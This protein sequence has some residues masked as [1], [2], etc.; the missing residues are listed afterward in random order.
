MSLKDVSWGPLLNPSLSL[1]ADEPSFLNVD[2]QNSAKQRLSQYEI[3]R[4]E[5]W[6]YTSLK[7]IAN[8]ELDTRSTSYESSWLMSLDE[9]PISF[10]SSTPKN[11]SDE[12][13]KLRI[14]KLSELATQSRDSL[15]ER[16]WTWL[17]AQMNQAETMHD[18]QS[19]HYRDG[20]VLIVEKDYVAGELSLTPEKIKHSF[21]TESNYL[22]LQSS[23]VWI[24]L[25]EG[26]CLSVIE[27]FESNKE[28]KQNHA[29][30]SLT[31][32][33]LS[34]R[35]KLDYIRS[36]EQNRGLETRDLHLGRINASVYAD[37]CLNL[38][39]L[40]LGADICRL[41]LDVNLEESRARAD[42]SGL[43]LGSAK[44]Q[45]DQHLT[46]RHKAASCRS[47]QCFKGALGAKSLGVFTGRV[48]V[49]EG[50][51][52]TVADQNNPNLL[53]SESAKAVTRPQLEIYNDD[54][55]CSHGATVGQLDEDALFYLKARGLDEA[56]ALRA[57]TSAF[58]GEIRET[59]P[60]PNLKQAID[61]SLK[62][63]LGIAF[64]DHE[65]EEWLD[66]EQILNELDVSEV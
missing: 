57:L 56:S 38:T 47:S 53:L 33:H 24:Y 16:A 66:W 61:Y 51:F 40:N 29:Q 58:V 6:R 34:A 17:K 23:N 32:M 30:L 65:A 62:Q 4:A 37:A 25:D 42:L 26:A 54:V 64:D 59:L 44:A 36:Q 11:K 27:G 15:A 49:A 48:I 60:K 55:E 50:S 13:S 8:F 35:S 3:T 1:S 5:A 31:S 45:L 21:F 9:E 12:S 10:D 41:E 43:Y 7:S 52:D 14:L 2:R 20:L 19:L 63:S 18:L 46:L 39:S 28:S 22:S